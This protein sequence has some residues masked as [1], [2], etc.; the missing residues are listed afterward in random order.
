[1][2][3]NETEPVAA[4]GVTVAVKV[5]EAPERLGFGEEERAVEVDMREVPPA[6]VS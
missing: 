1:M 2:S 6:S 4:E 3:K 5:T